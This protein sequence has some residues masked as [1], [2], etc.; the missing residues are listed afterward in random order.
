M[1]IRPTKLLEFGP[2]NIKYNLKKRFYKEYTSID[3]GEENKIK[4]VIAMNNNK[5]GD[6]KNL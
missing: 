1:H 5:N 2:F 6:E 4:E 3:W